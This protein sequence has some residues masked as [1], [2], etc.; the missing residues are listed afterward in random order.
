M[1]CSRCLATF[2]MVL[3]TS[4]T[5][6]YPSYASSKTGVKFAV[7]DFDMKVASV[8]EKYTYKIETAPREVQERSDTVLNE[9]D[10]SNEEKVKLIC[11]DVISYEE[12][13]TLSYAQL[14]T[15]LAELEKVAHDTVKIKTWKWKYPGTDSL[16]KVSG[17]VVIAVNK[18]ISDIA[19][20]AFEEIYNDPSKP[21]LE[22][23]GGY[24][25]RAKNNSGGSVTASI[26][27]YG[28]AI[29]F[30]TTNATLQNSRGERLSN[31]NT[32]N[33]VFASKDAW[34]ALPEC[35]AKYNIFYEDC[36]VVS[37][38]KKYGFAWG[39]DWSPK[40]RDGMHFQWIDG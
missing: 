6:A 19:I 36:A 21:V 25:R 28:A 22:F 18:A 34:D 35:Q 37:I 11:A 4:A 27:A 3:V 14:E 29:D 33:R 2:L 5:V 8:A 26:H 38:L 30:N 39:G 15:K 7:G 16:E 23:S 9:Y 1:K 17:E 31:W 13:S 12:F 32:G 10:L 40:Y 24:Y 20:K